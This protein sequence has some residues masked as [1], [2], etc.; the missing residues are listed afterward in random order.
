MSVRGVS[1][2]EVK[3]AIIKGKKNQTKK[4]KSN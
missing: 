1:A 3:E 4:D 2:K